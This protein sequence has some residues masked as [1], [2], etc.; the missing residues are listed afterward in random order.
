VPFDEAVASL[1][2]ILLDDDYYEFIIAGRRVTVN[3]PWVG[4]DRLIPLKAVAWLDLRARKARGD[5][6]DAKDVRK[7]ANDVLRLSQIAIGNF[8]DRVD[9]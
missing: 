6:V 1:S 4:E 9:R 2:V 7:H 8:E 5:R 3:L